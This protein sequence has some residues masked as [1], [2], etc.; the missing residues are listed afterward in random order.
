[1]CNTALFF[2]FSACLCFIKAGCTCRTVC[3]GTLLWRFLLIE[4]EAG[5]PGLGTELEAPEAEDLSSAVREEAVEL[6]A[7]C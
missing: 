2:A 5:C 7:C 3:M 4:G 1:M 6:G